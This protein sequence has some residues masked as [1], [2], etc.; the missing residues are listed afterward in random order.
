MTATLKHG[1]LSSW[2]AF[3]FKIE[4]L[5]STSP[6]NIP[7][8]NSL[9]TER[10]KESIIV[11][12]RTQEVPI[13]MCY[14][15]NCLGSWVAFIII[16]YSVFMH[17]CSFNPFHWIFANGFC[18]FTIKSNCKIHWK[19]FKSVL[20]SVWKLQLPLL[21]KVSAW[22]RKRVEELSLSYEQ[23]TCKGSLNLHPENSEGK[24][25]LRKQCGFKKK[26]KKVPVVWSTAFSHS[27]NILYK[28]GLWYDEDFSNTILSGPIK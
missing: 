20:F 11:I 3:F 8:V 17:T 25:K 5:P 10:N 2:M 9:G 27:I 6:Q 24:P 18:Y 15:T 23:A 7:T 1:H 12:T 21:T 4:I 16:M 22:N 28:D 14:Q 13:C 19:R 26:K